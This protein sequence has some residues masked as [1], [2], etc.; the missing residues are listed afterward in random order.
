MPLLYLSQ[1]DPT[2]TV[3]VHLVK[4][5]EVNQTAIR[6]R[7]VREDGSQDE[8]LRARTNFLYM[9]LSEYAIEKIES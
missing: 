2:D 9:Q 5:A 7:I 8:K 3:P 1:T 6:L 4:M